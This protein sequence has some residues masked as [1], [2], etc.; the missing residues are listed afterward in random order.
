MSSRTQ[1]LSLYRSLLRTSK[2]FV[3]YN[4]REYALR[5]VRESF[6]SARGATGE[7]AANLYQAGLEQHKALKRQVLLS[8]LYPAEKHAMEQEVKAAKLEVKSSLPSR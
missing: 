4:F 5:H 2:G 1:V 7:E 8:Q 6:A 3:N